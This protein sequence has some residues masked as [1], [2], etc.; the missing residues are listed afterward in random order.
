RD[1]NRACRQTSQDLIDQSEALLD[2]ANAH[3]D[4]GVDVTGLEHGNLEIEPIVGRIAGHL[5][6]IEGAAAG[7][8]DVTAGAKLPRQLA[9]QDAPGAGHPRR[10]RIQ[11]RKGWPRPRR[12]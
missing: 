8:P 6:R 3:P 4:A 10:D 12:D 2:L 1:A 5:A 11:A 7:T 9:T